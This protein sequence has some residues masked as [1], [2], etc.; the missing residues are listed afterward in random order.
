M[1][2]YADTNE[3]YIRGMNTETLGEN[4][5]TITEDVFGRS[6][7][8]KHYGYVIRKMINDG[9]TEEEIEQILKTDGLPMSLNLYMYVRR[10]LEKIND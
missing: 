4:L 7:I 9:K 6:S 8:D 10:Q 5:T 2:Q 3:P 1:E